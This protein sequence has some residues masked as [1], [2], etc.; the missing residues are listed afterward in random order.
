MG[1][2]GYT[3]DY[4]ELKSHFNPLLKEIALPG[5]D[6]RIVNIPFSSVAENDVF[7]HRP[8]LSVSENINFSFPVFIPADVTSGKVILLLHGLNERSWGKYLAWA[9]RLCSETASYVV[10]FPISFHM[11]RAP[12]SWIDPRQ[13]ADPLKLRKNLYGDLEMSSFANIALSNRLTEDPLRFLRSGYQTAADIVSLMHSISSGDLGLIPAGSRVNLFAYSIG[14]FLAQ[15]LMIGNPDNLFAGSKLFMFCGGS[16]F[17]GMYGTSKLIMDNR[18]YE[19]IY[20]YYVNDFEE[21]IIKRNPLADFLRSS[22]LGIAFRSMIDIDRLRS[23]RES[24]LSK[25]RD[26]IKIITLKKD[27]VIPPDG[28][29]RTMAGPRGSG[30]NLQV[31]DFPYLYSHENPFPVSG[32]ISPGDVDRCFDRVMSE[33]G[34]F[35]A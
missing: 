27:S 26:R 9:Y 13:L 7:A 1:E 4:I 32:R 8:D 24:I 11:N 34:L 5:S 23:F 3:K 25:L 31:W 29:V 18:A 22:Q 19:R 30:N 35:L 28:I 21:I 15:I 2:S 6:I 20:N 12:A 16:V 17:S 14:A 10:L 33:A